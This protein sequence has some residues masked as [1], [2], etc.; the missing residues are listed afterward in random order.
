M[1]ERPVERHRQKQAPVPYRRR[2]PRR[3]A[4]ADLSH[5]SKSHRHSLNAR[6]EC[7]IKLRIGCRS[8]TSPRKPSNCR[9]ST[10]S[11]SF[12]ALRTTHR[13][14]CAHRLARQLIRQLPRSEFVPMGR[15]PGVRSLSLRCAVH[16]AAT[17]RTGRNRPRAPSSDSQSQIL[18]SISSSSSLASREVWAAR[19]PC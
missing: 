17:A 1:P 7:G 9:V 10:L 6:R 8:S 18:S 14:E 2:H 13:S 5:R 4:P 3:G 15:R 12:A 19:A 11:R 16:R